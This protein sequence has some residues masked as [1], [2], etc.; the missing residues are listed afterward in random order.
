MCQLKYPR[1]KAIFVDLDNTL[2]SG[3]LGEGIETIQ[4]TDQHLAFQRV[5]KQIKRTGVM[6]AL[7]TKNNEDEVL[8]LFKRNIMELAENDFAFIKASWATK[9]SAISEVL[10]E[11][12]FSSKDCL[13]IDD[14][15][16]E[17]AEV[18]SVFEEIGTIQF[19]TNQVSENINYLTAYPRIFSLRADKSAQKREKDILA[20]RERKKVLSVVG[21]RKDYLTQLGIKINIQ[22]SQVDNLDRVASLALKT[23]QFNLSLGRTPANRIKQYFQSPNLV[24]T[25]DLK[26]KFSDS[27]VIGAFLIEIKDGEASFDEVLFSC[28]ALGREIEN[29]SF[30]IILEKLIELGCNSVS[31]KVV[32]GSRNKPALLWHR[33]IMKCQ[34][35]DLRI[36]LSNFKAVVG[37]YRSVVEIN[38]G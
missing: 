11:F 32:D 38:V 27:G 14:N 10:E 7:V 26:D 33:E 29:I 24:V 28:R 20:N 36:Y 4:I 31:F 17:L 15:P 35:N 9:S 8:E 3:V 21:N 30:A 37:D 23:N 22:F 34:D 5:L 1:I 25:I 16:T 19:N 2:Y 12:N 13:F 6:L 18:L